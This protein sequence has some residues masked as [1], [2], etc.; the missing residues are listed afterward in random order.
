ML[1]ARIG[2]RIGAHV[3]SSPF[4]TTV[5]RYFS[6]IQVNQVASVLKLN[7]GNEETAV[8]LD[9]KMKQMT[10]MMRIM[11]GC[12]RVCQEFKDDNCNG[13]LLQVDEHDNISNS[14][15]LKAR[16]DQHAGE[17]AWDASNKCQ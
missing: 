5:G 6:A 15:D 10:E 17:H 13:Q 11:C 12:S 14:N 7:C 9:A 3:A 2:A 16:V 1:A 8:K 4:G